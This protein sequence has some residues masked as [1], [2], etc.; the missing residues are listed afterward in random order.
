MKVKLEFK[1]EFGKT[2]LKRTVHSV[3]EAEKFL[4][5]IAMQGTKGNVFKDGEYFM[6]ID[7][8][9]LSIWR[10]VPKERRIELGG[11]K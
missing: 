11:G 1:N 6:R 2:I 3:K 5:E 4:K 7:E 9:I 8:C 10:E